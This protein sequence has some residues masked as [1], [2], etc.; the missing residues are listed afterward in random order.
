MYRVQVCS[1]TCTFCT[2]AV[3]ILLTFSSD[4]AYMFRFLCFAITSFFQ[5]LFW[6]WAGQRTFD[7]SVQISDAVYSGSDWLSA[8][9]RLRRC[10]VLVLRRSQKPLAFS[11][12]PFYLLNYESFLAVRVV[13]D[14]DEN[15]CWLGELME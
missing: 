10:L 12:A 9:W 4:P 15:D 7:M 14:N 2:S 6:C 3:N 1:S 5:L 11:A 13:G 8:G